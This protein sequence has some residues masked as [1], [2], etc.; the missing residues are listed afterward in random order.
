MFNFYAEIFIYKSRKKLTV[1]GSGLIKFA[2]NPSCPIVGGGGGE[3]AP[4][5]DGLTRHGN[6][7][8]GLAVNYSD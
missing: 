8:I 5:Q 2:L 1:Q 6:L 4:F 7:F 3:K